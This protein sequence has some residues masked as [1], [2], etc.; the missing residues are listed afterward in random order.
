MPVNKTVYLFG[1]GA[2]FPWGG[3]LATDMNEHLQTF[4][5]YRTRH[6][7]P[8]GV[9]SFLFNKL[10]KKLPKETVTFETIIAILDSLYHFAYEKRNRLY[11]GKGHFNPIIWKAYKWLDLIKDYHILDQFDE[12]DNTLVVYKKNRHHLSSEVQ[13][14]KGSEDA[15]YFRDILAYALDAIASRISEYDNELNV[16]EHQNLN[17]ALIHLFGLDKQDNITRIYT[18]NYDRLV[19]KILRQNDVAVFDGFSDSTSSVY[20]ENHPADEEKILN[21]SKCLNHY[22]LHGS[23]YWQR[24]TDITG[25]HKSFYSYPNNEQANYPNQQNESSNQGESFF[26][27]NIVTG[28]NKLQRTN[29]PPLNAFAYAFQRDCIEADTLVMIGYSFTDKHIN[30]IIRNGII[31]RGNKQK[32]IIITKASKK[33]DDYFGLQNQGHRVAKELF[34]THSFNQDQILETKDG[35]MLNDYNCTVFTE[36]FDKF[37][38]DNKTGC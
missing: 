30:R 8:Q 14:P 11:H 18:L 34:D 3:P 37:L 33:A 1:A 5:Q 16:S 2:A 7:N 28:Y 20:E 25:L 9:F 21:D 15:F 13:L 19:P 12:D 23:I 38:L 35:F 10:K 26:A 27:S 32:R 24:K 31:A 22:N 17:N 6:K 4:N 36:G 29:L